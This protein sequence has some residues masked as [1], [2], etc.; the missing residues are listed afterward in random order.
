VKLEVSRNMDAIPDQYLSTSPLRDQATI[1]YLTA[2]V[3]NPFTGLLPGTN[4]NGTTISRSQLLKPYPQFTSFS[5]LDYQGYSWYH[6]VQ[7]RMERRFSKGFTALIGYTFS[8]TMQASFYLNGGDPS[9]YRE[10]SAM[11]RP[12]HLSFSG[13]FEL[14]VGR[15]RHSSPM[16]GRLPIVF[17]ASGSWIRYG[18]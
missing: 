17:S 3:P 15:G 13:I 5:M 11:D 2:D 10:I 16:P 12:Q 7:V 1:N 18:N 8:K 4:L 6:S 14:P 9:P